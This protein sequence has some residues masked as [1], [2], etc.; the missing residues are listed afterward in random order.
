[1]LTRIANIGLSLSESG[2]LDGGSTV[3]SAQ[4]Y[5]EWSI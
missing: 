3:G 2:K 5:L 4:G 1:M